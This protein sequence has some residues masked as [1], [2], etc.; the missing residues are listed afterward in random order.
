VRIG[1]IKAVIY[2]LLST[3]KL[4]FNFIMQQPLYLKPLLLWQKA[5]NKMF[6]GEQDA[7]ND[8]VEDEMDHPEGPMR[9]L[10]HKRSF[11]AVP[12]GLGRT[13]RIFRVV[14][15]LCQTKRPSTLVRS[16]RESRS[17]R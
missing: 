11:I 7:I 17:S 2:A 12:L 8:L 5:L 13:T 6:N 4:L 16:S 14:C 1:S 3:N 15:T 10:K 9:T